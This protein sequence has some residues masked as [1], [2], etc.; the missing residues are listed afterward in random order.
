[1]DNTNNISY[2]DQFL[3]LVIKAVLTYLTDILGED[4]MDNTAYADI[5]RE[6]APRNKGECCEC[7]SARGVD[8]ETNK[9]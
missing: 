3:Q 6:W 9:D 5:L 2:Q 1:M 7:A 4:Y 8:E